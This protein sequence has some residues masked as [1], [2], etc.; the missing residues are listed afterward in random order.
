M[1]PNDPL[2]ALTDDQERILRIV[3]ERQA[4]RGGWVAEL[5]VL[6]SLPLDVESTASDVLAALTDRGMVARSNGTPPTY[7]A[8]A[9]GLINSPET[10]GPTFRLVNTALT[11][12]RTRIET[13]GSDFREYTPADLA[14]IDVWVDS[15]EPRLVHEV[16]EQFM[17]LGGGSSGVGT[18]GKPYYLWQVPH[19]AAHFRKMKTWEDAYARARA[20]VNRS[21]R[22]MKD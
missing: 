13:D 8:T 1:L 14:S 5:D 6:V 15:M 17:L 18:D 9:A 16:V 12:L 7:R 3:L 22:Y 2:E 4:A 21:S 19:D 10:R 11:L 20:I